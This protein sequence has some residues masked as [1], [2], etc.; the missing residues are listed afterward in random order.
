MS[1]SP[2]SIFVI[3]PCFNE[4]T[5]IKNTVTGVLEKG[6]SV[7]VV[8]DA[9]TDETKQRLRGLPVHYLRHRI[10]LGQ[11]AALQTGLDYAI[12][13]G[14]AFM[15]T[16]D[17]DGQHFADD[18]A[19]MVEAME[20]KGVDIV[21]GSR[22]LKGSDSTVPQGRKWVLKLARYVNYFFS[23]ILLSDAHNGF[24]CLSPQAARKIRLRENR[25]AHAS[26]ILI[27]VARLKLTYAEF[28]V[29]IHYSAYSMAKGQG[30][31][32]GLRI[33][34]ELILYKLFR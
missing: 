32:H 17:A 21:F 29:N 11:G 20:E 28:P 9:S 16:F 26:E 33:L 10:N 7:V 5:V 34:F 3:I 19:G 1:A 23:G 8:D 18:I 12:K 14:A 6:Y 27:Q 31:R 2:Q 30:N 15:I 22:F 25:M 13:K 4:A 24:R